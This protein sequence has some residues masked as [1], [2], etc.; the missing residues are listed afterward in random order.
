MVDDE[1][2]LVGMY[3]KLFKA[4]KYEGTVVTSP[5]EA[6]ALIRKNP[7]QFDLVITD[8]TMPGMSGL[9][10]ARRIRAIREDLP[11]ILATG[12]HSTVSDRQLTDAGICEVVEK[13][14]SMA[15]LAMVLRGI[16]GKK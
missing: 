15:K 10:V 2:V 9:E 8:L 3:Q 1:V 7:A 14:I 11:I 16:L 5:E 6:V 12:F 13:P 4:L